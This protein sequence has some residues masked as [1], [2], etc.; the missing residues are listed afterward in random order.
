M[1]MDIIAKDKKEIRWLG[2]P[3]QKR[4][5]KNNNDAGIVVGG[6]G[7][8]NCNCCVI[9]NNNNNNSTSNIYNNNN[10]S[11]INLNSALSSVTSDAEF[12]R[13]KSELRELEVTTY[14]LFIYN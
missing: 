3:G 11:D 14:I 1:A 7:C 6:G 9:G 5:I 4:N 8:V 13:Q 10:I 12:E 2:L